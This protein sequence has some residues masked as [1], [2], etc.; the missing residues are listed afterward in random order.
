MGKTHVVQVYP[1]AYLSLVLD[2]DVGD[3]CGMTDHQGEFEIAALQEGEY[4]ATIRMVKETTMESASDTNADAPKNV[5]QTLAEDEHSVK[6]KRFL[7]PI[8]RAYFMDINVV[9]TGEFHRYV[10][11]IEEG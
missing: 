1:C 5:Q 11:V 9:G 7:E 10:L 3:A 4:R 2:A 6:S 8:T